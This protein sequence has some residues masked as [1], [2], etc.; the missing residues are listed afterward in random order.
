MSAD[1]IVR[2]I[3][4]L[5]QER[6]ETFRRNVSTRGEIYLAIENRLGYILTSFINWRECRARLFE[7]GA[8]QS[9][10]GKILL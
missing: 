6:V 9:R 4:W 3:D 5:Q 2:K 10:P 1:C 8:R 7:E